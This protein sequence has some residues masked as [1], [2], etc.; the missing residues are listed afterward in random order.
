MGSE[1]VVNG[2]CSSSPSST[3]EWVGRSCFTARIAASSACQSPKDIWSRL[4]VL[5][6]EGKECIL[7]RFVKICEYHVVCSGAFAVAGARSK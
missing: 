3:V 6:K 2:G 7:F 4:E 1:R 5:V